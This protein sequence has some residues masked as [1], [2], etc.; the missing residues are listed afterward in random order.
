MIR[1]LSISF[2]IFISLSF[3]QSFAK[4]F[5][6]GAL[7]W[8]MNIEGQVSMRKGLNKEF[9]RLT[10]ADKKHTYK[11]IEEVAGDG[12][13]G[14]EKQIQQ[15]YQMISK[16]VDAIIIQPTNIA[17]LVKPLKLANQRNIPVVAYDQFILQ[18]KMTSFITSNN[19]Q[20]GYLNGEYIASL[21]DDNFEIRLILVEYPMVSSTV[22]R[23][24]GFIDAL[25]EHGQKF[26]I[27]KTY[28]AVEPVSGANAG[29]EILR[30]FP[31]KSS[32]DVIF[33]INDGGGVSMTK[34]I[35]AAK[36]DEIKIATID[37]D[38][39]SIALLKAGKNIVI[40][41]AQFC[42]QLGAKSFEILFN[43]LH[44]KSIP[45]KVLVPVFPITKD[46][47]KDYPGWDGEIP[48]PFKKPWKNEY[49]NNKFVESK[50]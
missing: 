19:Y 15:M 41:T 14:V 25:N 18:G 42:G 20:A 43:Y 49:W 9:N 8:S 3:T 30:D 46:T 35:I 40:N 31:F 29:D 48:R 2:L 23:V 33:T 16:N 47:V 6:I 45:T 24:N 36:R 34:K 37:G 28:V 32:I 12:E 50:K 44:G 11:L 5:R 22:E 13:A 39:E 27:L 1:S 38:P 4:E 17:A 10:K 7:Y 26:K 21:F